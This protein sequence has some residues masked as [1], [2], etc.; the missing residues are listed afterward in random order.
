M[1]RPVPIQFMP[2]DSEQGRLEKLRLLASQVADFGSETTAAVG[3]T[4]A[5]FTE[6]TDGLVPA[7]GNAT[8]FLRYDG[9]WAETGGGCDCEQI[10]ADITALQAGLVATNAAVS[11]LAAVV[12]GLTTT[13]VA[14]GS[15]LYFTSERAQDAVG[16]ILTDSS[17]VDFTYD[18]VA[19]TITAVV[20][21]AG[22]DHNTL[23]NLSTGDPHPQ[24]ALDSDLAGY[25][26]A[27]R[28]LTAGTGLTGGGDLSTNRSFAIDLSFS[29]TWT[30]NHTFDPATG[31]AINVLGADNATA[32]TVTAPNTTGQSFGVSISAGT[33]VSD[34]AF[35]VASGAGAE[36]ARIYGTGGMTLGTPTGGQQGLGS[37]NAVGVYDD[38]VLLANQVGA[39]P[40][41]SV[42]TTAIN[43]SAGTF[44]RSDAAPALNLAI[45]PV[46]TGGHTWTGTSVMV[47]TVGTTSTTGFGAYYLTNNAGN[48]FRMALAGSANAT[49]FITN[50]PTG[51]AGYFYTTS[52]SMPISVGTNG[53]ERL[54]ITDT[55]TRVTGNLLLTADNLELQLG[56]AQDL[57]LY[58]DGTDSL[59]RTDVGDLR[60]NI[61]GNTRLRV[62]SDGRISGTALHNVGTVTGTTDQFIASGTYT[63]TLTNTTNISASSSAVCQWM[64]VGNVVTVSGQVSVTPTAGGST[65]TSL[66]ISLPIASALASATQASGTAGHNASSGAPPVSAGI[67]EADATN[68]RARVIWGSLTTSA[69]PLSFV[70]TYVVL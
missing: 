59:V 13:D 47:N 63:P 65:L 4:Y 66:G 52:T 27:T 33:N 44:M 53:I 40:S 6:S 60:F 55:D 48:F 25:V 5:V 56:A 15:N 61:A 36:L 17:S 8:G 51:P 31:T 35:Y 28:T 2:H 16:G 7:P 21:S 39:N 9:T 1:K 10:E 12:A 58:H 37:L 45:T 30:G 64:R 32:L 20:L 22:V 62:H 46:W 34:F 26:P 68:D 69:V 29:P 54:R 23:A 50:G 19:N 49:A 18:D 70:F 67:V 3:P 41:A 24:Y 11:A 57:R 14:E 38:G 42:G 43:G